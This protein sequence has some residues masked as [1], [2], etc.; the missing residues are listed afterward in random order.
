MMSVL[1]S[2]QYSDFVESCYPHNE[3]HSDEEEDDDCGNDCCSLLYQFID[4]DQL[5][6][7]QSN[8]QPTK[9]LSF[10]FFPLSIDGLI[11]DIK[12]SAVTVKNNSPPSGLFKIPLIYMY[13]QLRL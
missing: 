3:L 5:N 8:N 4:V 12:E 9:V 7:I 11:T 1:P 6:V 2:C 10:L 13:G